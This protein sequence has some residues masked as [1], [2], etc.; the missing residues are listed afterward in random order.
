MDVNIRDVS[1]CP[2]VKAAKCDGC[3]V[4]LADVIIGNRY[5]DAILLC[6]K[7]LY[8]MFHNYAKARAKRTRDV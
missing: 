2:W 3:N 6:K 1:D 4:V 7:C 8:V 5:T